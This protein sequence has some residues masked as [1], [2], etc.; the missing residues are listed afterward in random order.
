MFVPIVRAGVVKNV[1]LLPSSQRCHG[2]RK[3]GASALAQG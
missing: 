2:G 1:E 3:A